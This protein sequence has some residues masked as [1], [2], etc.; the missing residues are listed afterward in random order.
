MTMPRLIPTAAAFAVLTVASPA[1]AEHQGPVG[2][3]DNSTAEA[4]ISRIEAACKERGFGVNRMSPTD[5]VCQG[6]FMVSA[7]EF[8]PRD[9]AA[10]PRERPQIYHRFVATSDGTSAIVKERSTIVH[11]VIGQTKLVEVT[12]RLLGARDINV[13]VL[14]FYAALGARTVDEL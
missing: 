7:K 3:F 2:K 6:G 10:D 5:V 9:G 4:A 8:R 13:R 14:E 11:R 12:P 1:L